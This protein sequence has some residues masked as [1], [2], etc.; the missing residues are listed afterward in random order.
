MTNKN[1]QKPNILIVDDEPLVR[2]LLSDILSDSSDCAMAESAE[3]ALSMLG[4]KTFNLVISDINLGGMTGI[5]LIPEIFASSPDTVVMMI[6]GNQTIDSAIEAIRVGAFDFIKKPFELQHV[7]VAVSR[8]LEHQLL[9]A[10]KRKHE[11]Q[12]EELVRQRTEQLNY[13][14]YHDVLTDL[15]NRIL[16]EDRLSQALVTTRENQ[17]VAV[18][19]ISPD[20][21]KEVR[22]TLGHSVESRLLQEIAV[23]L[24]N[25]ASEGAT[26]ARFEAGEFALLLTQIS[27]EDVVEIT[28]NIFESLKL[29][30]AIEGHEIFI[31]AGIGISLFPDDGKDTHALLKNAGAA[32]S[33]AKEQ[34]GNSY[35]F[36]TSDINVQALKR[37]ALENNLRRAIERDEFEVFYQPKID[38][39]TGKI[40]GMEAL[41]RWRHPEMGLISPLE[42]IPLAEETGLIVPIGEWILRR[43]CAQSRLWRD[44]G[45]NLHV[46][47]N[48]SARQFQEPNLSQMV[49]EII[50]E[51]GFNPSFLNLEVT[52]SSIMK[53]AESAVKTLGELRG[54]GIKISIDDFGTGYS[55]LG[56]L[57]R[58][59]IDVL[60]IDKS[61]IN[62]V[63]TNPDDAAL[64]MA[65]VTLA[66]NLKLKVVAEGVETEDQ[67]SFLHLLRC[68][69]WQGFLY[70]RPIPTGEFEK[71]LVEKNL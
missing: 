18:L 62:D 27:T 14:A 19:F 17:K 13:L 52:E 54:M 60:K 9:L 10:G 58:L 61:F 28:N 31:T 44:K 65:I 48:L 12:L 5:E 20:R 55:S 24:K 39:N 7:E 34:G 70:S 66:H 25:Y 21:I 38:I 37:L 67:L 29:P 4:E 51:T 57:K 56:Y 53:N 64:V 49:T 35:Q 69:E 11:N 59:P 47:V 41:V 68:D 50:E 71:L 46:A 22:D 40:V 33:R 8:A 42:F 45:F 16:F 3:H 36:Y 32:L 63:T 15:P 43:S 30:F 6:S 1:N 2:N 26:V 23:R